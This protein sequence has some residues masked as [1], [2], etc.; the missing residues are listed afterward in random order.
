MGEALHQ[1]SGHLGS[2]LTDLLYDLAQIHSLFWASVS[3]L[4]TRGRLGSKD[5][6][7]ANILELS[8]P[9]TFAAEV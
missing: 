8:S 2:H 5:F 3:S 7:G 1:Q 6:V 9:V 4:V